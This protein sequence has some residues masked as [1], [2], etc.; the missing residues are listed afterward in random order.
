MG[1]MAPY[2]TL[3][4]GRNQMAYY[5]QCQDMPPH[6]QRGH[7]YPDDFNKMGGPCSM[8]PMGN[9]FKSPM[10]TPDPPPPPPAKKK[11]RT[12]NAAT[13]T[14]HAPQPPPPSPQDLL[15]PPLSGY[16]D[17]IVASNP[18]DDTPPP[19][20]MNTNHMNRQMM[21]SRPMMSGSPCHQM[22]GSPMNCGP[23]MGS[24][25]GG[26]C[27]SS[28]HRNPMV[29]GPPMMSCGA[30]GNSPHALSMNRSP[31][32]MGSPHMVPNMR[33][34]SPMEC[35]AMVKPSLN[36]ASPMGSPIPQNTNMNIHPPMSSPMTMGPSPL[37]GHPN[38]GPGGSPMMMGRGG[39]SPLTNSPMSMNMPVSSA[40]MNDMSPH[41][42]VD[43]NGCPVRGP[44]CPGS[45]NMT[46]VSMAC[47]QPMSNQQCN[48][49]PGPSNMMN[50]PRGMPCPQ[51]MRGPPQPSE[52]HRLMPPM[53]H[54]S[55]IPN[56]Q[57]PGGYGP[58]PNSKPMPVSAGKIYPH[59]QPMVFNPQN[60]NAPPIYPCGNCH[61]EVHD[62]DQAVLCE[63]GCNFWFHRICTGLMEPAFQLLTAEVYAEW[64]CDKC[65]QTKNIP[66]VKY[67]P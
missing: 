31:S 63:S 62:N 46:S 64:V 66:L 33:G 21:N 20:V 54:H 45:N 15:P 61:K 8:L 6:M 55:Q 30:P 57:Q 17:T 1:G 4:R 44:P 53:M 2:V 56:S 10:M 19:Q 11:R 16:G 13:V 32:A 5:N 60:P 67:K 35:A 52:Q 18:F 39:P 65:L 12:S 51:M 41:M 27:G 7:C 22:G 42:S 59:D 29:C 26:P 47:R 25:M 3:P 23:P 37:N 43:N 48:S 58:G 34:N 9:E 24:P 38:S 28:P 14:N 50:C 49:M 36:C 40:D